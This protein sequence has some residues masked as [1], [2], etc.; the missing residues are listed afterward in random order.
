MPARFEDQLLSRFKEVLP[1]GV[2]VIL[3][4]D[5]G[6]ADGVLNWGTRGTFLF[7]FDKKQEIDCFLP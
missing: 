6:F 1:E 4:A 7:W 3:L 5:R 2:K